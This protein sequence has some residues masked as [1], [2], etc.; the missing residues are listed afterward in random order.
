MHD[1]PS[2][3]EHGLLL[4]DNPQ[5]KFGFYIHVYVIHVPVC[6]CAHACVHACVCTLCVCVHTLE[7]V[8]K[9]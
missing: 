6:V 1:E 8:H 2:F 3:P 7:H 9:I 5:Q 4:L